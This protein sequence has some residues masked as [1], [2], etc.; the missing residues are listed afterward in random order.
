LK[1]KSKWSDADIDAYAETKRQMIED[2]ITQTLTARITA[3][4]NK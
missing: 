4:E 1:Q 3:L 2:N